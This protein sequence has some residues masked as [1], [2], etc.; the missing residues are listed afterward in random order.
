MIRQ[1]LPFFISPSDKK[2]KNSH[3]SVLV[4]SHADS[5]GV[6]CIG[7]GL[8]I[9]RKKDMLKKNKQTQTLQT[10]TNTKLVSM[11]TADIVLCCIRF[12]NLNIS[13]I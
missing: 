7:C 2:K 4:C 8:T 12:R 5:F 11:E 13:N 9:S 6:D 10:N 3:F 1:D